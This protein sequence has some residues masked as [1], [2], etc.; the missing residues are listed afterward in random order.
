[1][2]TKVKPSTEDYVDYYNEIVDSMRSLLD[3][4][5]VGDK[6]IEE[7][8]K[9]LWYE[10]LEKKEEYEERLNKQWEEEERGQIIEFNKMRL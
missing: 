8:L 2:T 5:S 4:T 7:G 1:M 9:V 10:A 3:M 6:D